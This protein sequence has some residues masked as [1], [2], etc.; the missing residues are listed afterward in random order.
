[1]AGG[2]TDSSLTTLGTA[3]G[4]RPFEFAGA[5]S[6]DH[7]IS[8]SRLLCLQVLRSCLYLQI[9]SVNIFGV[10]AGF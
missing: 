2:I 5:T 7:D 1:M 4:H 10:E 9:L 3:I 8:P 6:N